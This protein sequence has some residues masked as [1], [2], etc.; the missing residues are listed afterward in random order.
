MK[1][2]T[3]LLAVAIAMVSR[4]LSAQIYRSPALSPDGKQ[5]AVIFDGDLWIV[6]S[7]GGTATRLTTHE[8]VE[9]TPLFAPDGKSIAFVSRRTGSNQVYVMPVE[10]GTPKQ[11]TNHTEGFQLE[12]WSSDGKSLLASGSRDGHFRLPQRLIRISA[13]ERS[14]EEILF[15][16]YGTDGRWSPDGSKVLFCRE[17]ERWWRKGYKGP[18]ASQIWI[19]DV[20]SKEFSQPITGEGEFRSPLWKADGSGFYFVCEISGSFNIWEFDFATGSKKPLTQFSDDAVLTP[21]ISQDGSKLVFR[22]L[23]DLYTLATKPGATPEKLVLN[24]PGDRHSSPTMRRTITSADDAAFSADGLEIIIAAGGDLWAMDTKLKEPLRITNTAGE[25]F[26]PVML[27]SGREVLFLRDEDGQVDLYSVKLPES[28][29]YWWNS[30]SFEIK[31][32]TND[33]ATE[34]ELTLSPDGS[35]LFV[36]KEPGDLWIMNPDGTEAK[37]IVTG[38]DRPSFDCSPDGKWIVYSHSDEYFNDEVFIL[39][40]DG[41]LPPVNISRHPDDDYGPRW[42]PDGKM[43]AFLGRRENEETDIYF[44]YLDTSESER[45]DRERREQEAIEELQKARKSKEK[46]KPKEKSEDEKEKDTEK[47]DGADDEKKAVTI[48]FDNIFLRLKHIS[49]PDVAERDLMWLSD[50]KSITFSGSINGERGT[51]SVPIEKRTPPKKLT[52][53]TGRFVRR[54][55]SPTRAAWLV[56]GKPATIAD[57]GKTAEFDFS[58]KQEFA[59]SDRY[60]AVFNAGW[61]LMKDNWYDAKLNNRNWKAVRAKYEPAAASAINDR[62]LAD[63]VEMMLGEL[64]GSH[65]GITYRGDT[66]PEVGVW[67]EVTAHLGLRFD[68]N[69]AGPGLKVRDV[70]ING[71]T[72]RKDA[73][74]VSGEIV[75]AV[76]DKPVD[77]NVDLTSVLNGVLDRDIKLEIQSID[78]KKRTITIRPISYGVAR[79]LLYDNFVCD[80]RAKVEEV[81]AGK[82]GYIHIKGMGAADFLSFEHDLYLAGYGKDGLVIDVRENR[83]GS[84]TDHL[85]TALTQPIHAITVP[86]GGS[87][88]YPHDRKIYATWDK[89]IVVLCNQNSFSNAEVFSHAI[90]TLG[91]GPIVGV[92]TGGGVISTG[93]MRLMDFGMLRRP[94]RGWYLMNG[95]SMELNGAKPDYE[96]WLVPGETAKGEDRQLMKAIEVLK[97]TIIKEKRELP[98]L[99]DSAER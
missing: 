83:G 44:V 75:L 14:A 9:S 72:Y 31:R 18:A 81:S 80:N 78:D 19:Y 61:R 97:E 64:N 5:L 76:D 45:T 94:F 12:D 62:E 52:A 58:V 71:P 6:P 26:S 48:D 68:L 70:L 37:K 50:S 96:I 4:P 17:G 41:S 51:F 86:R 91:R 23:F 28:S 98:K 13:T 47:K 8:A 79:T 85:L 20:K 30:P 21:D 27:N 99:R 60:K 92:Q 84:I 69:Y 40:L 7:D 36:S 2:L 15:D 24:F 57:D 49:V 74:V 32:I 11:L 90:K 55:K 3:L 35:K 43:I 53:S 67:N 88:G 38:F 25:E 22:Y 42:S 95:E 93:S 89:P 1:R 66:D 16:D 29:K 73:K 77:R 46:D 33:E 54:L 59:V 56:S 65:L 82:M 87:P 39:A 63:V 10:G 34:A